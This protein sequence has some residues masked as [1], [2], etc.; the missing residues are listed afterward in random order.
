MQFNVVP[1][2]LELGFDIRVPPMVK[3]RDLEKKFLEWCKE[4]GPGVSFAHNEPCV[5]RTHLKLKS[6]SF[7]FFFI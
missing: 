6:K 2:E 7:I 3:L 1:A 4:A 5:C